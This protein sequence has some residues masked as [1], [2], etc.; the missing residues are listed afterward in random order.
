MNV[1]GP[2]AKELRAKGQRVKGTKVGGSS[3]E[4]SLGRHRER[5]LRKP[6]GSFCD[7]FK[8]LRMGI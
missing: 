5:G 6:K 1:E 7:V 2:K 8:H 4:G 3:V